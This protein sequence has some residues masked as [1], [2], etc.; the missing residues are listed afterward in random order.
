MVDTGSELNLVSDAFFKKTSLPLEVDGVCWSLKGVNGGAVP[1]VGLIRNVPIDIG[2]HRFDHHF[3]MNSDGVGGSQQDVIL[4]QP[5]LQ[6]YSANLGYS[7]KGSIILKL[8]KGGDADAN[9]DGRRRPPTVAIQLSTADVTRGRVPS[10]NQASFND[11][12]D[13]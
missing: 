12:S 6:W 10:A 7:R 13:E 11:T 3:F 2:G 8:W 1:L 4:G 9:Y 5:W